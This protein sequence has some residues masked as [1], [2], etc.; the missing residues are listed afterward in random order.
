MKKHVIVEIDGKK[1][2]VEK[3]ALGKYAELLKAIK[4]LPKHINRFQ[5]MESAKVIEIL[6]ELIGESLPDFLRILAIATPLEAE[7]INEL[8]L[9][10]AVK[11]VLAVVEVNNYQEVYQLAK[12]ALAPQPAAK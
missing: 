12:K 9:D 1:I 7:E 2:T 11:L 10:D 5:G 3:L 4:E 8:G 6:P